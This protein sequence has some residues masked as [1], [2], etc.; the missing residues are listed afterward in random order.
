MLNSMVSGFADAYNCVVDLE[1]LADPIESAK[2]CR[3]LVCVLER[4]WEMEGCP[5]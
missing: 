2:L 4:A 5:N 3:A 1:R